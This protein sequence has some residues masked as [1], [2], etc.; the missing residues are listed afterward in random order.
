MFKRFERE[1]QATTRLRSPHTIIVYDFGITAEGTFYYVMEL[2]DGID[3]ST[4]VRGYGPQPAERVVHLMIQAC[5]S[6]HEAHLNGLVHRDIKPGNLFTCRYGADVDFL[7]IHDF[8]LVKHLE[9]EPEQPELTTE[10]M[11]TGTP[12]YMAPEMIVKDRTIDGRSDI[13]AL[14]CV[15]YWLLTGE[16]VFWDDTPMKVMVKHVKEFPEPPS[17]R[18]EL[19]IPEAL[20]VLILECLEKDA[21]KRPQTA[22]DLSDRL[23]ALNLHQ[24]WTDERAREWW[25]SFFP[26]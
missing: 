17:M 10:G 23:K 25:D 11:V 14:G 9:P 1:V 21:S 7:K 5:H 18:S 24:K 13:Y 15:A 8:G 12:T 19:E 3:V 26:K 2:L 6:L 22:R 4:L 20:D 16:L